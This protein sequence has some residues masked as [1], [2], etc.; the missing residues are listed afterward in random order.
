MYRVVLRKQV[1][2]TVLN[3]V[4]KKTLSTPVSHE[5]VSKIILN[6]ADL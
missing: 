2:T 1:C 6:T 4:K 5:D 3:I